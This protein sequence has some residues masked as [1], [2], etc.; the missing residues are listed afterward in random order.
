MK[1]F[2]YPFFYISLI[3]IIPNFSFLFAQGVSINEDGSSPHTSAILDV[4]ANDKGVLFPRLTLVQRNNISLPAFGLLI[5]QL[6]NDPGFYFFNGSA[7]E[8]LGESHSQ[9]LSLTGQSLSISGGNSI[10]L[11][12]GADNLGNH[13]AT[14][15]LRI[16]GN[17]I[18]NNGGNN[19]IFITND[20]KVGVNTNNPN[21]H[22][23]VNTQGSSFGIQ[24]NDTQNNHQ[25][26]LG[27]PGGRT[28]IQF[29]RS[30]NAGNYQGF[31][32]R[33][34]PN[35]NITSRYF[36]F[37]FIGD[38]ENTFVIRKGGNIGIGTTS[39]NAQLHTTGTV[40]F[41]NL[42]GSGDRMVITNNSG[43]LATAPIPVNTDNQNLS[44]S[45]QSLSI[46]GGNSVTLPDGA[47]NLGNHTAIQNLQTNGNWITNDG[48]NNGIYIDGNNNV[49]IRNNNPNHALDISGTTATNSL[50]FNSFRRRDVANNNLNIIVTE[51]TSNNQHRFFRFRSGGGNPSGDAGIILSRFANNNFYIFNDGAL[52]INFNN[53]NLDNDQNMN[54]SVGAG[55]DNYFRINTNGNVGIN[56]NNPTEKLTVGGNILTQEGVFAIN[57]QP[58]S[59]GPIILF[60]TGADNNAFMRFGAF[61][62]VNNIDTKGR[63]FRLFSNS[64]NTILTASNTD[65]F[66]GIGY[67]SPTDRL[68]V[69][70]QISA[71]A[72]LKLKAEGITIANQT[73]EL[74]IYNSSTRTSFWRRD[75]GDILTLTQTGNVGIGTTTPNSQLHTTGTVRF[76]NLGGGGNRMVVADDN[77][78]LTAVA[79]PSGADNLGNHIATQNLIINN[80]TIRLRSAGDGN[81][82][83]GYVSAVDGPRLAGF[84]GGELGA[85]GT[86]Y[87]QALRWTSNGR[88]GIAENNPTATLDVNG[89]TRLRGNLAVGQAPVDNGGSSVT[90]NRNA[91]PGITDINSTNNNA[92]NYSRIYNLSLRNTNNAMNF[93][94]SGTFNNR[95]GMIQVGHSDPAF[96]A[97]SGALLLNPLG[98]NV[99]IGTNNPSAQLHT[100][101][102]VRHQNLSGSNTRVVTADNDGNLATA[103][104]TETVAFSAYLTGNFTAANGA[105]IPLSQTR[106]NIGNHFNTSTHQFIAP[107][108]G[109]YQFT[110]SITY[111]GVPTGASLVPIL[112]V[113]GS[114]ARRFRYRHDGSNNQTTGISITYN[115]RLNAGNVVMFRYAGS[116]T[117]LFFGDTSPTAIDLTSV[118]GVLISAF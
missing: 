70:G 10:T 20:N 8:K 36:F 18:S 49:G 103:P 39:P 101:G 58:S 22:F 65:G 41:Q 24:W 38:P 17:W 53:Q 42:G 23:Q 54:T 78:N 115:V 68:D 93:Y 2:I 88:V 90:I 40:R 80:N 109:I 82:T 52:K 61:N 13:I 116:N 32:M 12:I 85:G 104:L 107:V 76:Q 19:G 118:E 44:I 60:G 48:V 81:H 100:T 30:D 3:L 111:G 106:F 47:D 67:N 117:A 29:N 75:R 89:A 96:A 105:V 113:N 110:I 56:S 31:V 35:S 77:G 112:A 97:N 99:S 83:L 26:Y 7:W 71:N 59:S 79:I 45:G 51:A 84:A 21:A 34:V 33:N 86:S 64:V 50:L 114:P 4:D 69:N 27:T 74:H 72:R 25:I 63:D 94:V 66:I 9:T 11:P 55:T 6:D 1:I 15:N 98:G 46:S 28:G 14:Q 5:Y 102:T 95:V 92:N 87:I 16:N 57:I 43:N 108:R 62:N 37:N 91:G 73:G